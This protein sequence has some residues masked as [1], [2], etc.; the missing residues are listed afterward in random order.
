MKTFRA[1][2]I[3]FGLLVTVGTWARAEM[4]TIA[5]YNIENYGPAN[6]LTEAGYRKDYPKPEVEKQ[7]LRTVLRA[8]NADVLVLQEMGGQVYLDE[9]RRDLGAEGLVYPHAVLL[10]GDDVDRHVALLT[11]RPLTAA[12]QHTDLEMRYFGKKEMVKR[13]LLEVKLAVADGELTIFALHLKSRYTDRPDDPLSS[14][15]RASEATAIRDRVLQRC[16]NPATARFVV[17]GDC[18]D[19]KA[20]KA[21]TF[22]Q[23][24][25]KTSIAELLPATDS[26]GE[27]WTHAYRKNDTY[28]RVDHVLVSVALRPAVMGG[29]ARIYDGAGW[30]EASDHRP[31]VVTLEFLGKK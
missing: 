16:G 30:R 7:A 24:R 22:L 4:L 25:G 19:D 18:N 23:Q 11:K 5:T 2:V 21:L 6:R 1:A 3:G 15:R 13:G 14:I 10:V 29:T 28:T 20:S 8:L 26:R 31:V 9:L 12:T 27:A 17:L